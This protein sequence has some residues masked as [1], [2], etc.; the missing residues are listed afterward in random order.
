M[1]SDYFISFFSYFC[2]LLTI[3]LISHKKLTSSADFIMGNRSL[4]Y[5]VTA[6]SAH[7]S[8]M[9]SWLFMGF[10]AA[11][12]AGGL[13]HFWI[14]IGVMLGMFA[15]WH[16]VAA[17]L[18]TATEETNSY[19]LSTFF[20]RRFQDPSG[21]IRI[22]TALIS[23]FFLTCYLSAGLIAMGLLFESVFGIDYFLG[24]SIATVVV[25]IYTFMGGFITVAWTDLFQALFLLFVIVLVPLIA[26]TKLADGSDSILQ[27][28]TAKNISLSLVPDASLGSLL[29]ILFLLLSW[30]LG[31]FGQPHIITKFMGIRNAKDMHKSKYLGMT[32][33]IIALAG[34]TSIAL[35]GIG[36]FQ[37]GAIDPQLVFVDMVKLLFSPVVAGFILCA[38]LAAN[39]ST[40]D[41]QIL[42]CASVLSED[43]YKHIVRKEASQKQLLQ[44][45]RWA[46]IVVTLVALFLAFN[47][48]STVLEAVHYA[49]QGLGCAFGPLVLMALY[50][51]STN[52]YGAIAGIVVG[53]V[54]SGTWHLVNPFITDMAIQSMIPGFALSLLSIYAVSAVTTERSIQNTDFKF[55]TFKF[56]TEISEISERD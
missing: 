21:T 13:S 4:N 16:F 27:A 36:F 30:G 9:S 56:T 19:T 25:V 39:M 43:F 45:S 29:A 12:F 44:V 3:G 54:V 8:D 41:S 37:T 47:K 38:V 1:H 49:W 28:A 40:M 7:A 24:I 46:V 26:F 55:T 31:Y 11:I 50:S 10:P 6:L 32:W 22:L 53:G 52:R 42:V 15:N 48:S 35:I 2:I 17:K 20:E 18:R 34:A 14:A 33:Q 23:V 51:S 5:W